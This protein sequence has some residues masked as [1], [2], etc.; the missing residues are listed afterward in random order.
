MFSSLFCAS[1]CTLGCRG[2]EPEHCTEHCSV[3]GFA[4]PGQSGHEE[5]SEANAK[6]FLFS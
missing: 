3:F 1:T 2:A 4:A 6:N 5:E